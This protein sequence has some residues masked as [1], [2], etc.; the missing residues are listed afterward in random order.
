MWR[1]QTWGQHNC[2]WSEKTQGPLLR[3]EGL[4]GQCMLP[5]RGPTRSPRWPLRGPTRS[6]LVP[7]CMLPLPLFCK[8]SHP[9]TMLDQE[10]CSTCTRATKSVSWKLLFVPNVLVVLGDISGVAHP[11]GYYWGRTALWTLGAKLVHDICILMCVVAGR[12]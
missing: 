11:H 3:H 12:Q 9:K 7:Q 4:S 1:R 5:L 8:L 10:M 6:Q 2:L